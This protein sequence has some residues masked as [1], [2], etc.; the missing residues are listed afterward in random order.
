MTIPGRTLPNYNIWHAMLQVANN[1]ETATSASLKKQIE[2]LKNLASS[3]QQI[4]SLAP[5]RA[6][7]LL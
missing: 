1:L 3:L 7:P 5:I 4:D 6:R 2:L